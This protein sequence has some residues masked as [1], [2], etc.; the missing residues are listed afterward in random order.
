[1]IEGSITSNEV[2]GNEVSAPNP[3]SAQT[4]VQTMGT[5]TVV[6]AGAL[7]F[8]LNGFILTQLQGTTISWIVLATTVC[9]WIVG[10]TRRNRERAALVCTLALLALYASPLIVTDVSAWLS[11]GVM[12]SAIAIS[13]AM[14]LPA[15]MAAPLM[16]AAIAL[17]CWYTYRPPSPYEIDMHLPVIGGWAA[18]L[19]NLTIA[20]GL[21]VW[22]AEWAR[23]AR[24]SD[25]ALARAE[26]NLN[27]VRHQL[28]SSEARLTVARS[29]HETVLNTLGAISSG[30]SQGRVDELRRVCRDDLARTNAESA[31]DSLHIRPLDV[32]L[33]SSVV[34]GTPMM[35][36]LTGQRRLRIAATSSAI[37]GLVT[38]GLVAQSLS[39]PALLIIGYGV[40]IMVIGTLVWWWRRRLLLACTAFVLLTGL[41]LVIATM[42]GG[43][44]AHEIGHALD[45][46]VNVGATS[47][48]LAT[49]A[50]VNSTVARIVF[51][52]GLLLG[53]L[54]AIGLL[55]ADE[56]MSPFISLVA[57][58]IYLGGVAFAAIWLFAR[59]D[60]RRTRAVALMDEASNSEYARIHRAELLMAW[61]A[62]SRS[63]RDLLAGIGSGRLDPTTPEIQQ[64][65]LV[66]ATILRSRLRLARNPSSGLQSSLEAIMNE[67]SDRG[68]PVDVR[69]IV[70][71]QA[72]DGLPV[73]LALAIVEL[74]SASGEVVVEVRVVGG[75]NGEPD[76]VVI[77]A[78]WEA[79][80]HMQ[81]H[82][83][84]AQIGGWH[85]DLERGG[86]SLARISLTCHE[87]A[88]SSPGG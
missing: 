20:V 26:R 34:A 76:E 17:M 31:L 83:A 1:L 78:P 13:S 61:A 84:E 48:I 53:N 35:E 58:T 2:S 63:T 81:Q 82:L 11:F 55:P 12:S 74:I 4:A 46:V 77:T 5:A 41:A 3:S 21:S 10:I 56:R 68:R 14:A 79:S 49:F 15:R 71:S 66:E 75:T 33:P 42:E 43:T 80:R 45:W 28:A 8:A 36:L 7:S 70:P 39:A 44:P 57:T 38:V 16:A 9:L 85:V 27:D 40:F 60:A 29:L 69:V 87:F 51:P 88:T 19:F 59:I 18:P 32:A 67:A 22:R 52:W 23:A 50:I 25:A 86:D 30:T 47:M 64:R 62:V 54:L 73:P 65:A 6:L 24:E 72:A 37:F